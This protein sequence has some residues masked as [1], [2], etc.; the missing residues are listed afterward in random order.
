MR[1]DSNTVLSLSSGVL[2]KTSKSPLPASENGAAFEDDFKKAKAA[3]SPEN[4][5]SADK[6]TLKERALSDEIHVATKP[7]EQSENA[8]EEGSSDAVVAKEDGKV[9]QPEGDV[10][11]A[12]LNDSE[13]EVETTPLSSLI[14]FELEAGSEEVAD[15]KVLTDTDA[16]I[17][18]VGAQV[19][20]LEAM[21]LSE[22]SGADLDLQNFQ[23]IEESDFRADLQK[24]ESV[25]ASVSLSQS[26]KPIEA[27]DPENLVLTPL[28]QGVKSVNKENE[29]V[30]VDSEGLEVELPLED[31]SQLSWV[32]SQMNARTSSATGEGNQESLVA[33]AI[34]GASLGRGGVAQTSVPLNGTPEL[35]T[36]GFDFTDA[37]LT[38]STDTL[39]PDDLISIDEPIELRK[40]EQE[41]M[42][43]RMSGQIDGKVIEEGVGNLNNAANSMRAVSSGAAAV[44][45]SQANLT[46]NVPPQH[47][48]WASEMS[49]KVAWVARD[50]GH[51]A[52]IR[53]DPP[54]LGSLT[55]K[56]SVDNDSNT[57]VSFIAATPQARDLLEGQMSRLR[58]MLA[59]QGMDLSRADV[60][61]SQQDTSGMRRDSERGS[62][63]NQAELA[64][65]DE[66]D[67]EL[68][69]SNMSYVTATGVDYYA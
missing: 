36:E 17:D 4:K 65:Q 28:S 39:L 34:L 67:D 33:P 32:L 42:L 25:L 50:G 19:D 31:D 40:K 23:N 8:S 20:D 59:Q 15:K 14:S 45:A 58:D 55:V 56:I 48:N 6:K 2:P 61:V 21:Q 26:E 60:D 37:A 63:S 69:S 43:S 49:Q 1:T 10:S 57:Q 53:L 68:V 38:D 29:L 35:G 13:K 30:W 22:L 9:L 5:D 18:I 44:T 11:P 62:A 16:Y 41:A 27:L 64:A 24:G 47:P 3:F 7:V 46:M 54:E 66:I 52:H 51:T 12:K